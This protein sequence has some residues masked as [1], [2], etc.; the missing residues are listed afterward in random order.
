MA[1]MQAPDIEHP[2]TRAGTAS[3]WVMSECLENWQRNGI[4][5]PLLCEDWIGR[6]APNGVIIDDEM[7]EGAQAFVDHAVGI[8]KEHSA[9]SKMLIEH[10]VYMP[11]IHPQNWGT[12]DWALCLLDRE[13]NGRVCGGTIYLSDYKFG[14]RECKVRGNLQ[15]INYVAGLV[16][17][18]QIDGLAEQHIK[19][20]FNI[21]QPFCY[22]A[23]S[24]CSEWVVKLCDLRA[25]FNQ[26]IAKAEEA[27][28]KPT[29]SS[30]PH[31]RDC[32]SIGTCATARRSHYSLIDYT[33]EPCS[34]DRMSGQ[35]M[36]TERDI[37]QAGAATL[38]ARLE[39]IDA[40]LSHQ[41]SQG[42][43]SSG[44]ALETK[45][46]HLKWIV[47]P[48][49]AVAMASQFGIAAGKA[50]VLTPTQTIAAASKEMKPLITQALKTVTTR[51]SGGLKLIKAA[52][53][54]TAKA[55]QKG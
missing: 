51:P 22:Q 50:G 13:P 23:D 40:Q 16:N 55:F 25:Y 54:K 46:G 52:D 7:A 44:L 36:A 45:Y 31:C 8:A 2:R 33:N 41:V 49:Q 4:L 53:S 39:A 17:E 26:L 38:K 42:D 47:P 14:H 19:V 12:L 30:G 24:D 48:A 32:T 21:V 37:L 29:F 20:V 43:T 18:F 28:N 5:G 27:F 10:R 34:I 9:L 1:N 35:D 3:H 11:H 15:P 6:E